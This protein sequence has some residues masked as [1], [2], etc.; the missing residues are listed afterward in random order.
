MQPEFVNYVK[1]ASNHLNRSPY[2]LNKETL[3]IGF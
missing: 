1:L 2:P 3:N